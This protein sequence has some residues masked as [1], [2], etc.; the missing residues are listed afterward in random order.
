LLKE[1]KKNAEAWISGSG[2]VVQPTPQE[3]QGRHGGSMGGAGRLERTAE[4]ENKV[5]GLLSSAR[6]KRVMKSAEFTA[7]TCSVRRSVEREEWETPRSKRMGSMGL[8][9]TPV[10]LMR[11]M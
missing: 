10:K 5:E 2:S 9:M 8:Y 6:L 7:L 11:M 3:N 4:L 1:R